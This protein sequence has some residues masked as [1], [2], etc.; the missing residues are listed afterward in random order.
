[1]TNSRFHLVLT[2][3]LILAAPAAFAQH[4]STMMPPPHKGHDHAAHGAPA[5]AGPVI[6]EGMLMDGVRTFE[7]EVTEDGFVPARLKVNQGETVRL[8]VTRK[9]DGTC[10]KEI[11]IKDSGINTPLPLEKAVTVE[12]K[13]KRPGEV[14]FAC[15]MDHV[16]GLVFVK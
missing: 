7:L 2:A 11:V 14:R 3:G 13:A 12:F 10:A 15:G 4:G 5:S 16:S 1:M 6:A 9:T 8:V